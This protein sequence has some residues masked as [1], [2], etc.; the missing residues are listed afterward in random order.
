MTKRIAFDCD[1]RHD[2]TLALT[3]AV[4]PPK[5][6]VLAVIT[7]AGNQTPDKTLDSVM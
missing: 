1:P 3:M 6:D 4:A 5:I 7:S 2:D